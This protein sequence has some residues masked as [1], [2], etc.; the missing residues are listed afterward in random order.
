MLDDDFMRTGVQRE[1]N[2]PDHGTRFSPVV[3][4]ELVVEVNAVV[5]TGFACGL[6]ENVVGSVARRHVV[7]SPAR[8][9]STGRIIFGPG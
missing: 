9:A 4:N 8:G 6:N 5:T 7:A 3:E 1:G 2:V